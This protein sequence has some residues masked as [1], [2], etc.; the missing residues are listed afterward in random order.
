MAERVTIGG[1]TTQVIE[2][3]VA[4]VFFSKI[5]EKYGL[6]DPRTSLC[7]GIAML[8]SSLQMNNITSA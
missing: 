6:K 5:F 4:I 2:G 7:A 1:S 8:S 3:V